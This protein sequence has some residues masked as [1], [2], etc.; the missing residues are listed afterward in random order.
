MSS[1]FHEAE[2]FS[3]SGKSLL[4]TVAM[5]CWLPLCCAADYEPLQPLVT[6]GEPH[7]LLL[8]DDTRDK[9]IPVLISLPPK[10]EQAPI[11][12]F[13][14]GLGGSRRSCGYLREHWASRG[15]AAVFLQHPE[16]DETVWR[17]KPL[18]DRLVSLK[19]AASAKNLQA[20]INDVKAVLDILALWQTDNDSPFYKRMNLGLVAMSGHSFGAITTQAVSGQ[21]DMFLRRGPDE[22]IDAAIILSPSSPR[23]RSAAAAFGEVRIPWLLMTGTEDVSRIGNQTVSSRL[24]V[25]PALPSGNKYELVLY[26]AKHSAF[27]EAFFLNENDNRRPHHHLAIK[28]ISTAFLDMYLKKDPR[29]KEWLIGEGPQ[30]VLAINDRWQTK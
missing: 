29:A 26:E 16:S 5:L 27:T 21:K 25:F 6:L 20:R 7:D 30:S 24:A 23:F 12:L 1:C 10:R 28:S 2:I 8:T 15:Y 14:H 9:K 11:V 19:Q 4:V 17:D 22:R 3:R 13:S 18:Q